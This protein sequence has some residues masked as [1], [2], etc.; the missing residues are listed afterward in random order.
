MPLLR[1]VK[2]KRRA[3]MAAPQGNDLRAAKVKAVKRLKAKRRRGL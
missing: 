1:V 2:R 3:A